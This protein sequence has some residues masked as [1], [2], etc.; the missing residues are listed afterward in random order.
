MQLADRQIHRDLPPGDR[1]DPGPSR[2]NLETYAQLKLSLGLHLRRQIF[3]AV[4][5]DLALRNQLA[6]Q[7]QAELAYPAQQGVPQYPRFMTLNLDVSDP[8]PTAQVLEWLAQNPPPFGVSAQNLGFQILG[9]ERLIRQSARTQHQFLSHLQAIEYYLPSFKSTLLLWM[10]R[11][12]LRSVQQSAPNFWDWHSA[13]FE[14]EGDPTPVTTARM[15]VVVT[16]PSPVQTPGWREQA[17]EP[18]RAAPPS[19][20][21]AASHPTNGYP[22]PAPLSQRQGPS[23][24][25][26]PT[27]Q[28]QP[29]N[30]SPSDPSQSEAFWAILDHDLAVLDGQRATEADLRPLLSDLAEL[31]LESTALGDAAPAVQPAEPL[32]DAKRHQPQPAVAQPPTTLTKPSATEDREVDQRAVAPTAPPATTTIPTHN[33]NGQAA[34]T[35]QRLPLLLRQ[36]ESGLDL[37]DL[38]LSTESDAAELVEQP[39]V[40]LQLLDHIELLQLHQAAP[41]TMAAAYHRLATHFRDRVEQGDGSIDVLTIAI[42]AY[43]HTLEWLNP[44]STLQADVLNDLGNLYW[45]LSRRASAAELQPYLEQ[46]VRAYQVALERTNPHTSPHTY[47]MIQN[48]LGSAYSDLAQY[49]NAAENLQQ[50][51]RAYE[52]ALQYRSLADD[53]ARYAATQNNLGTACW[54]LA[55][56]AQPAV[57][58]TRAVV[59]YQEALRYYTAEREPLHY[60]MIQNN[61]G[62]AYW[63]LA[64]CKPNALLS[65]GL[66]TLPAALLHQA[67]AAYRHALTYRTLDTAPA[68]YAATQNN[69]G[70][71]YWH[72]ATQPTTPSPE[73]L[74][75]LHEAIV[76]YTAALAAAHDL[77][78]QGISLAFDCFATHNNLGLAYYHLATHPQSGLSGEQRSQRLEQALD[79]HL[80]ALNGW[81]EHADFQQSALGYVVQTL[82][83]VNAECGLTAQTQVMSK[84]PAHLLPEIMRRI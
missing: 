27:A 65:V 73:R 28:P 44:E 77:L 16:P 45:M 26:E 7:L 84:I 50:A 40:S 19:S 72:L 64:Q 71:A 24:A 5:D 11:P 1:A 54:N 81:A 76:V 48:N 14:F 32:P 4:C 67:I 79:Q 18:T 20:P 49:Q 6:Q 2:R 69:L 57:H 21:P 41:A 43:E 25:S 59:A 66:N 9:I 29:A 80:I 75:L 60:A 47:A 31:E 70:T 55:Q 22:A 52:T 63:N 62:T 13:L 74:R 23:Q 61:L 33:G 12:W 35:P 51:V 78:D 42:L 68:A 34:V 8:N 3:I 53:P 82:R 30:I 58:L 56:H 10:P 36:A 39:A 83:A 38:I 15:G 17:A 37:A 46:A